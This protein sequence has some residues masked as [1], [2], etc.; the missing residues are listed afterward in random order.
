M[1]IRKND[2]VV[3][4]RGRNAGRQGKVLQVIPKTERAI[5]E[6]VNL[7]TKHNRKTQDN[8]KG[9]IVKKEAALPLCNLMLFCSQCKRGVRVVRKLSGDKKVRHCQKCGQA[10]DA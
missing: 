7:V 5:V 9:G 2:I 6:G 1:K 10:F 4:I 8:P 3:A